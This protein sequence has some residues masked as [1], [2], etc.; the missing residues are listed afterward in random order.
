MRNALGACPALRRAKLRQLG[1]GRRHTLAK[2]H[3]SNEKPEELGQHVEHRGEPVGA[4]AIEAHTRQ[5]LEK[6]HESSEK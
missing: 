4:Q 5:A 6:R 1:R 3:E 2:V